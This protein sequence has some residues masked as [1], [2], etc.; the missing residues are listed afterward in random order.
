M[1]FELIGPTEQASVDLCEEL[2]FVVAGLAGLRGPLLERLWMEFYDGPSFT[3]EEARKLAD[4]LKA[5]LEA[6]NSKPE[7]VLAAWA[8]Q[9]QAYRQ[10]C[11]RPRPGDLAAKCEELISVCEEA[12]REGRALRS[13]SD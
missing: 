3:T 13:L 4:E 11:Q 2:L 9:P 8:A 10:H 6:L 1:T 12:A 7:L 5:L